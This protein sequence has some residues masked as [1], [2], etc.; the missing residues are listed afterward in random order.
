LEV[1]HVAT[2]RNDVIICLPGILARSEE[3][4]NPLWLE[5]H[6]E[7]QYFEYG[8]A[9]FQPEAV[10]ARAI[11]EVNKYSRAGRSVT[12]LGSSLG[13]N[14]AAFVTQQ[15]TSGNPDIDDWFSVV[16]VDAPA[17]SR[18]FTA[19]QAVPPGLITSPP[20]KV[21]FTAIGGVSMFV[22]RQGPG[23]PK[24]EFITL[25]SA[26]VMTHL[27]GHGDFT[28][29]QWREWVKQS[30]KSGLSGHSGSVWAEQIRWMTQ[31]FEDGSLDR[32][33]RSLHD[34]RATYV[35]CVSGNDVV[36]QP[37]AQQWWLER[38]GST[39]A[40]DSARYRTVAAPHCGYLQMQHEFEDRLVPLLR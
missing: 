15:L 24:D 30:A 33:A 8:Q 10:I 3:Q 34:R 19:A 27:A 28:L 2:D 38:I 37:K 39:N 31:V 7:V 14:V 11:S 32:A 36:L 17:G 1:V 29:A 16:L 6:A 5:R 22:S 13:G 35:Q 9:T 12:L 18:T 26:E 20:G 23:L 25:P 4:H 21:I 40:D